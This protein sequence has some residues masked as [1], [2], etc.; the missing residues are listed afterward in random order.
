MKLITSIL[1]FIILFLNTSTKDT[2][3]HGP[4]R[5]KIKESV[6]INAKSEEVWN[7]IK[8]FGKINTWHPSIS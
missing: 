2:F 6:T 3:S 8:D 4:T 5:Q 7:V 1:F